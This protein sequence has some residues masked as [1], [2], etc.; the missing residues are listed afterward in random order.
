MAFHA[1]LTEYDDRLRLQATIATRKQ[2]LD[3]ADARERDRAVT[4]KDTLAKSDAL[5][6][7]AQSPAQILS[8]LPQF[9]PLP[10]PITLTSLQAPGAAG[11]CSIRKTGARRKEGL[12][13]DRGQFPR[14]RHTSKATRSPRRS[15]RADSRRRSQAAI[16]LRARL[17]LLPGQASERDPGTHKRTEGR[18]S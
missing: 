8:E 1:W 7:Q 4:L 11:K 3:A 12:R 16:G 9:L 15:L 18:T 10:E 5:K 2:A 14:T 6:R 17:P 13:P